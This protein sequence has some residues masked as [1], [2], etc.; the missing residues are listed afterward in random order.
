MQ[1]LRIANQPLCRCTWYWWGNL[2]ARDIPQCQARRPLYRTGLWLYYAG[3]FTQWSRFWSWCGHVALPMQPRIFQ[4]WQT[5][6]YHP[7]CLGIDLLCRVSNVSIAAH[8]TATALV[9]I[10]GASVICSNSE[11]PSLFAHSIVLACRAPGVPTVPQNMVFHLQ[12][13]HLSFHPPLTWQSHPTP[14]Q[15]LGMSF[16][17]CSHLDSAV[18]LT[19]LEWL[20]T[21]PI[22]L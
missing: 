11:H 3:C 22:S 1:W 9:P 8:N 16:S 15:Q 17:S 12:S 19:S 5:C 21:S 20:G 6:D 7:P 18:H 2:T 10:Y 4:E 14:L 13:I